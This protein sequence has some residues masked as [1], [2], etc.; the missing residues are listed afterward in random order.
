M[1][2]IL[3]KREAKMSGKQDKKINTISE[4]EKDIMKKVKNKKKDTK[5]KRARETDEF[6]SIL[7]SYKNKFLKKFNESV[8]KQGEAKGKEFEEVEMSD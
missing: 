2:T 1:Q 4:E 5:R 7:D 8:K 6:D 3:K